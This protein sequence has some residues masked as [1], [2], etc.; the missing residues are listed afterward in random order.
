MTWCQ[1]TPTLEVRANSHGS[2][3]VGPF[4]ASGVRCAGGCLLFELGRADHHRDALCNVT[5]GC[6]SKTGDRYFR[7]GQSSFTDEPPG[8]F[9][10]KGN[11]S[12]QE[13]WQGPL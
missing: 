10:S 12:N 5:A 11:D 9:G 2:S 1:I 8:G 6:T 7:I 13:R 3:K 4:E